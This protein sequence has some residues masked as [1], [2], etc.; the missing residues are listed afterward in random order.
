MS[1]YMIFLGIMMSYDCS[2]IISYYACGS[3]DDAVVIISI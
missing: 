3:I 1:D 2:V